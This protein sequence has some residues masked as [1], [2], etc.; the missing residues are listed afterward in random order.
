MGK[1][2]GVD[3]AAVLRAA[4]AS[5]KCRLFRELG[6]H[7]TFLEAPVDEAEMRRYCRAVDGPKMANLIEGSKTPMLDPERLEEIGYKIAV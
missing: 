2:G 7:I 3:F 5:G 6:A 4:S 1:V